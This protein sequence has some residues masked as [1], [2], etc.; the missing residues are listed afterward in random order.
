MILL[1]PCPWSELIFN[2]LIDG[3]L[4]L[5]WF[6]H[7][8][9]AF[10]YETAI[11]ACILR[12]RRVEFHEGQIFKPWV[13]GG[14]RVVNTRAPRL[15]EVHACW[16]RDPFKNKLT[17]VMG[18][19]KM[20]IKKQFCKEKFCITNGVIMHNHFGFTHQLAVPLI[21]EDTYGDN[22]LVCW[23]AFLAYPCIIITRALL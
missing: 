13:T 11:R 9:S 23:F 3:V 5:I 7:S 1:L 12:G 6:L 19:E 22:A 4:L 15:V 8:L 21:E 17:R 2:C 18:W 20:K 14:F 10:I 16:S